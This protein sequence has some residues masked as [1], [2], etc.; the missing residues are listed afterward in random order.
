LAALGGWNCRGRSGPRAWGGM[1]W[2]PMRA[3]AAGS[4]CWA[5]VFAILRPRRVRGY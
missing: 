5:E 3:M 1:G 4:A 2:V